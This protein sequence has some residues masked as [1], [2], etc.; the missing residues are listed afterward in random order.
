MKFDSMK[1]QME[2]QE[3]EVME[4]RLMKTSELNGEL[5]DNDD[6]G[7]STQTHFVS[8]HVSR[9]QTNHNIRSLPCWDTFWIKQTNKH[10]TP[11]IT[12]SC[13]PVNLS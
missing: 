2:S 4:A 12:C 5:D 3:M 9:E 1:K 7:T 6:A 13:G 11:D 10:K 8:K